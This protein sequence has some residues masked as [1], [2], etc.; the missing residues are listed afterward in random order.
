MQT[1][2][3]FKPEELNANYNACVGDNG[4]V[5]MHTYIEGYQSAVL[6]MLESVLA[7]FETNEH[8]PENV[9]FW[10]IDT[11]IYPILFS[12]RHFV[13]L[14]LK[15]NIHTINYLKN[16]ENIANK[17]TKTHDIQ[18][19]WS[20]FKQIVEKTAD[21]RVDYFIPLVEP[22]INDFAKIDLTGE[23]FRYPYNDDYSQKHLTDY[24]VIGLHNFYEK[25][26]KL[27][28]IFL[29]FTD[30]IDDLID[31][32]RVRTY[33]KHLSR[34]DI[35]N[36]AKILPIH[37]RWSELSFDCIKQSIKDEYEIGSKELANV[38]NI[39]KNHIEFKTYI[40]PDI[41]ELK[42]DKHKLILIIKKEISLQDINDFNLEE[43]SSLRTLVELGTGIIDG[44]YY[45]ED[46]HYL[47]EKYLNEM[48]N[49][50]Y[51]YEAKS[52]YEYSIRNC[53]RIK[54]GLEKIGYLKI[55]E[56]ANTHM[57]NS[58]QN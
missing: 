27:S 14:Y 24:S 2:N 53:Q 7:T 12:A 42:I 54:V 47:Y 5:S 57:V 32:Y 31:E 10:N 9:S 25:F 37:S 19:L 8:V 18:K 15:Q 33:T 3:L 55:W 13:E 6:V 41:Y 49:D 34:K 45:S 16:I 29:E 51:D 4:F 17:I 1:A 20:L 28:E 23:T 46:Y 48:K 36:I 50:E 26:N 43:I 39:I 40:Y 22:Y 58:T 52:N 35:E 21:D 11:A 44:V 30:V 38:I 56:E